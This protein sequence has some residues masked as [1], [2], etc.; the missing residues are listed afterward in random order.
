[1]QGILTNSIKIAKF[2]P[3]D[4]VYLIASGTREGPFTVAS[5]GNGRYTLCDANGNSVKDGKA[6]DEN[7]LEFH[8]AFE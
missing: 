6:Y 3:N 4:E 5:V 7:E 1:M 8:N 2:R